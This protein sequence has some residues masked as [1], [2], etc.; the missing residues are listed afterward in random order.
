[1]YQY[2]YIDLKIIDLFL[3]IMLYIQTYCPKAAVLMGICG[4]DLPITSFALRIC[5]VRRILVIS[6]S[7]PNLRDSLL[8]KDM[9]PGMA[10]TQWLVKLI[11]SVSTPRSDISDPL[12]QT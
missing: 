1:M 10:V 6:R 2:L 3:H 11:Q 7:D 8:D 4:S 5:Q 12:D 9:G